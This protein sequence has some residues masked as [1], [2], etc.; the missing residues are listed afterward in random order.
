[1]ASDEWLERRSEET[2]GFSLAG[3][4]VDASPEEGF[5][6]RLGG[7]NPAHAAGN[8]YVGLYVNDECVGPGRG[9]LFLDS[10]LPE[11]EI[12]GVRGETEV[13]ESSNITRGRGKRRQEDR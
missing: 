13:Y 5:L 6:S 4:E 1:M 2:E 11:H 3:C 10:V 8:E 9:A 12:P 7:D